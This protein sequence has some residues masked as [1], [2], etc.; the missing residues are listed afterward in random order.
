MSARARFSTSFL[1]LLLACDGGEK[2]AAPAADANAQGAAQAAPN[3][4]K[5]ESESKAP[6]EPQEEAKD[7][8]AEKVEGKFTVKLGGEEKVF[9]LLEAKENYTMATN[10]GL[11]ASNAGGDRFEVRGMGMGI[12]DDA[13]FP[14]VMES[15][16]AEEYMKRHKAHLAGKGPRTLQKHLNFLYQTADGKKWFT[17][18]A[19]MTITSYEGGKLLATLEPVKLNPKRKGEPLEFGGGSVEVQLMTPAAGRVV[20]K[21]V[22][23]Q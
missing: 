14:L 11:V 3:E 10:F 12:P 20:E 23:G 17:M 19:K 15:E 2:D 6:A 9:D 21:A 8:A 22:A 13:S 1:C 18:D 7:T 4:A 5:A 16:P